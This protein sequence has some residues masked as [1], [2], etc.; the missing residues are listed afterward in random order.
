MKRAQM[1]LRNKNLGIEQYKFML[2]A[3]VNAGIG[4]ETYG[5]RT[6]IAGT[7]GSPHLADALSEIEDVVFGTLDNLFTKTGVPPTEIDVLI[8]TV[9]TVSCGAVNT[10]SSD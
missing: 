7:E 5:P 3:L 1:V 9:S 6:V 8:V 2:Q 10:G 4:E